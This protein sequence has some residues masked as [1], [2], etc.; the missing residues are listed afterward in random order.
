MSE[1]TN[2]D[3]SLY[4]EDFDSTYK[5]KKFKKISDTIFIS[6]GKC[7]LNLISDKSTS[8]EVNIDDVYPDIFSPFN[9]HKFDLSPIG[10]SKEVYVLTPSFSNAITFENFNRSKS[11]Y[12]S[13]LFEILETLGYNY[14]VQDNMTYTYGRG[15]WYSNDLKELKKKG[16]LVFRLLS[17]GSNCYVNVVLSKEEAKKRGIE[18]NNLY[19]KERKSLVR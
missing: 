4:E 7:K 8:I 16:L 6:S 1:I 17:Y 9:N 18:K 11:E 14:G 12:V 2:I 10:L 5:W 19:D 3:F 15:Y 13:F